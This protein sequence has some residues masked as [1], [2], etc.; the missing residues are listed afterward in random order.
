MFVATLFGRT[1]RGKP[2]FFWPPDIWLD[3]EDGYLVRI[4]GL[5]PFAPEGIAISPA[6]IFCTNLVGFRCEK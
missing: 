5:L 1:E 3:P 6:L 2:E 4:S